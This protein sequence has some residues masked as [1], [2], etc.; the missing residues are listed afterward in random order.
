MRYIIFLAFVLIFLS[1][2][3]TYTKPL[4]SEFVVPKTFNEKQNNM[5]NNI[6]SSWWENFNSPTL[7]YLIKQARLNNPDILIA[8]ENLEQAKIALKISDSSSLPTATLSAGTNAD[9]TYADVSSGDTSKRTSA[10]LKINYEIDLWGK[11]SAQKE[12]TNASFY[13]TK[14]DIDATILTLD[15]TVAQGYFEYLAAK[16]RLKIAKNSL[17][18]S[19][20]F[21]DIVDAKYKSG[22]VSA[23]DVSSQ[24]VVLLS[25]Q[26]N[27]HSKEL[28]VKKFKN[29]LAVLVGVSP[30]EF[31]VSEDS[32]WDLSLV[33]VNAG[34][35][36]ELLLNRPDIASAQE[37]VI[38]ANANTKV[39]NAQRFP[40]FS[41]SATGG[42]S[43]TYLLSFKDPTSLLSIALNSVYTLFDSGKLKDERDIEV[44]RTRAAIQKY[45]KVILISLQESDDAL[46]TIY[47]EKMQSVL[48]EEILKESAKS[49][50][51][52]RTQYQ[53][54]SKDFSSLL[55]EQKTYY[56]S[57]DSLAT[58]RLS[59]L[60]SLVSLYR[61]L[62]GGWNEK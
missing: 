59:H 42:I 27:I 11:I 58:Q 31:E 16:E 40:S 26:S 45:N 23:L 46:S 49:L 9:K 41:L 43:S 20:K 56:S 48:S 24:N 1:G 51:I 3:S 57:Q 32:F 47:N 12:A 10:S 62:G 21:K 18:V 37:E 44:S 38:M 54:G 19:Q 2:C 29:I 7:G 61:V 52:T 39:A 22:I 35:P 25:Q 17:E 60:L 53:H 4:K 6:S 15:A 28:E 8:N 5:S 13:A 50:N 14:Y 34:L 36:S 55:A 30:Q 33:D